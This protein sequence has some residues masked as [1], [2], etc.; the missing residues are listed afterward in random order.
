MKKSALL[1]FA[2]VAAFGLTSRAELRAQATFAK[3]VAFPVSSLQ[4]VEQAMQ[5]AAARTGD[6][7]KTEASYPIDNNLTVRCAEGSPTPFDGRLYGCVLQTTV[8]LGGGSQAILANM[9]Y[10]TQSSAEVQDILSKTDANKV[11][12]VALKTPFDGGHGSQY[13]CN[14]EGA[15]GT[16]QW[17]CYLYF[18]D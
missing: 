16:R 17:A 15:A 10:L 14:A 11:D 1:G 6:A 7:M 5:T 13:F 4:K 9:L 8:D 3:T 18:V 2:L 12:S